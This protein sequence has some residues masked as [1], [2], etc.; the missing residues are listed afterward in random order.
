VRQVKI[1]SR[2]SE[3]E[4]GVPHSRQNRRK[5]AAATADSGEESG[6]PGGISGEIG[7]G[8]TERRVSALYMRGT[9]TKRVGSEG[10]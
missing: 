9:R 7:R 4:C 10:D 3:R 5:G 6:Q 8:E 2:R 1:R